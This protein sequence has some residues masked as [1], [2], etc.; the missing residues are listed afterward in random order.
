M[1]LLSPPLLC[2]YR[3]HGYYVPTVTTVTMFLQSA[4][5]LCSY[6]H[7]GY[8]PTVTTVT[9]FLLSPMLLCSYA[10]YS[11]YGCLGYRG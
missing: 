9:M 8:G 4:R 11:S 2:S 1:F 5:L 10:C 6:R 7:H 3:H